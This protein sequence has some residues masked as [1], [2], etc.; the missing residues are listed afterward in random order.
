MEDRGPVTA[1]AI[2]ARLVK[3]FTHPLRAAILGRLDETVLSPKELSQ[4]LG[5]PLSVVSY[6]V[7][8]LVRLELIELV[9]TKRRRGAVQH[10]YRSKARGLV[11]RQEFETDEDGFAEL[12]ATLAEAR[13][14]IGRIQSDAEQRLLGGQTQALRATVSLM[15]F[16]NGD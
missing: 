13:E 15:L 8:E 16:E 3:A 10:W 9:R 2:H 4:Q 6:H 11:A 1:D 14:R 12:T 5:A 7:K